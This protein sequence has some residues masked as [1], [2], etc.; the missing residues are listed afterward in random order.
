MIRSK[1]Q[2]QNEWLSWLDSRA[3]L[4]GLSFS[5]KSEMKLALAKDIDWMIRVPNLEANIQAR[6][7]KVNSLIDADLDLVTF[8]LWWPERKV[9]LEWMLT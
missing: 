4:L 3:T 6:L 2:I 1:I 9:L 8:D 5:Q 7:D